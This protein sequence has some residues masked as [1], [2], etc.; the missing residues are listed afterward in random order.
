MP[1]PYENCDSDPQITDKATATSD[2]TKPKGHFE[3]F[4]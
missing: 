1:S 3:S 2:G 4:S